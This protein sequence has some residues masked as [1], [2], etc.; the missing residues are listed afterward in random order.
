MK[1]SVIIPTYNEEKD[2]LN[3]LKSLYKQSVKNL[4]IIVVDDGSIDQTVEL[5]QKEKVKLLKQS[6]LGTAQARNFGAANAH[7]E[8]LVF[9]DA[10]M[11]FD[12]KFIEKLIEPI[13]KLKVIGTF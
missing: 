12:H 2:I 8:I 4:E 13:Q 6:H 7:G 9:V 1:V 3:C 11:T 10:D 5:V